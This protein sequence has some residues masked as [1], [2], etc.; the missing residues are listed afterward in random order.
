MHIANLGKVVAHQWKPALIHEHYVH[1]PCWQF[2]QS[3]VNIS[4]QHI[5]RMNLLL[6]RRSEQYWRILWT[7]NAVSSGKVVESILFFFCTKK[8]A[9]LRWPASKFLQNLHLQLARRSIWLLHMTLKFQYRR[10]LENHDEH[11][12]TLVNHCNNTKEQIQMAGT[13]RANKYEGDGKEEKRKR[14]K[15]CLWISIVS[16]CLLSTVR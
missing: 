10:A 6:E 1:L 5:P 13:T 9:I 7:Q 15:Y 16:K 12:F 4:L 3:I 8:S 14:W 11:A 2:V